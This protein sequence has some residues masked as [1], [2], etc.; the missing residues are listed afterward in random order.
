MTIAW[1]RNTGRMTGYIFRFVSILGER[2]THGHV[3]DF[4]RSLSRDASTLRVLGDGHQRKSYLYIQDCLDAILTAMDKATDKVNVFNLGVD[5]YVEVNDS[6][7][8]ICAN[9]HAAP[10]LDY[11]GGARGWIG[12]SPFIYLDTAKIR[13]LG[14]APKLSILEGV[15]RTVA[16]L[17][18]NPWV[19]EAR[20]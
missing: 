20:Q 9:M 18:A 13:A 17:A 14:W 1:L 19:F 7:A 12:D 4:F 3:F 10:K 15:D 11:A 16:F 8:R 2:Y 6:I 5:G